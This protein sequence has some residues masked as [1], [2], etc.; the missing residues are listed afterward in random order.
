MD[1]PPEQLADG[2][3]HLRRWQLSDEE[4]LHA[5]ATSSVAELS[6]WMPWAA[7][8][9]GLQ[10]AR[11]FLRF[12]TESWESGR[13]YDYAILVDGRP[14][15]SFGL[16]QPLTKKQLTL[17]IGYWLAT[18]ATGRG[19]ATRAT[20]LLTRAAFELGA[21]HVQIRHARLNDRSSRVPSRLGFTNIGTRLLD[22]QGGGG[23]AEFVL[24]ELASSS[25][26]A[27]RLMTARAASTP[28]STG[29]ALLRS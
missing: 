2:D 21:E 11:Q 24:W 19:F 10:E 3:V 14:S 26:D 4:A 27:G 20:A 12:T 9:Y 23:E 7:H 6:P 18:D 29:L 17:E 16:M 13:Q 25:P 15:G 8:G 22:E 1:R 28:K 5:A